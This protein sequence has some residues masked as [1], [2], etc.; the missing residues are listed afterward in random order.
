[1]EGKVSS[2]KFGGFMFCVVFLLSI[3]GFNGIVPVLMEE[4]NELKS[5]TALSLN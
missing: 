5:P 2:L 4:K 3:I 1:M